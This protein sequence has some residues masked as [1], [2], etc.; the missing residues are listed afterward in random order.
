MPKKSYEFKK[1]LEEE[2][3]EEKDI[4]YAQLEVENKPRDLYLKSYK[5]SDIHKMIKQAR[6]VNG[7]TQHRF[8]ATLGINRSTY[9]RYEIGERQIPCEVMDKIFELLNIKMIIAAKDDNEMLD[10]QI[11]EWE[12][13]QGK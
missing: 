8:C 4:I 7:Y 13:S 12:D 9:S 2:F 6:L 10:E 3:E 5:F 11:K 1:R